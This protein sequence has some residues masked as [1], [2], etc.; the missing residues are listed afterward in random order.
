[1]DPEENLAVLEELSA[2]LNDRCIYIPLYSDY[3]LRAY[4]KD[5]GGVQ[6]NGSNENNWRTLYWKS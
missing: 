1:M 2:T 6:I 3:N 4:N 5:L